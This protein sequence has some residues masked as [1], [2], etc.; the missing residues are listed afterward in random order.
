MQQSNEKKYDIDQKLGFIQ[1]NEMKWKEHI[2]KEV[3][4]PIIYENTKFFSVPNSRASYM[5]HTDLKGG[6]DTCK[7]MLEISVLFPL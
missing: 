6:I 2:E 7:V 4:S 1:R 5:R 3:S